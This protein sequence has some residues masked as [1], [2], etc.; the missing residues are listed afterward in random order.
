[1]LD[2]IGIGLGP[3]NLS[4]A[5]LLEESK[6][7]S[8]PPL[9]VKF[10]EQ[11]EKFNWH[12]GMILPQT[13]LQVPFLADLVTLIN[14]TSCYSFLN[15]LHKH[16]R[17]LK[18]YFVEDF[19]I[20]RKEYNHYCQWVA[21][22]LSS[23][24]FSSKVLDVLI[25][26]DQQ[27]FTVLVDEQ[28]TTNRYTAKNI[29]IGTGTHAT[30]PANLK[31]VADIAPHRCMHS[32]NFTDKFDLTK[33]T[34]K[35]SEDTNKDS[36]P[37]TLPKVLVL[38]SGQSSA[39]VYRELFD[40]QF[41]ENGNPQYQLDWMT[42]SA[43]FFPME[44]SPLGLEHFSPSYTDYFYQL[45]ESVKQDLLAKQGLLYK[46]MG[47][48]TIQDIY[49]RLYERSIAN[50]PLYS[51]II[52]NCAIE[53]I[54][55]ENDKLSISSYQVEQKKS[56]TESYDCVIAG[57]GYQHAFPSCFDNLLAR[58]SL[59][60]HNKPSI[61]RDYR[62][63]FEDVPLKGHVFVQNQELH[64]HGI[65]SPDLGLGAY[66]AGCIANQLL[67]R[68]QYDTDALTIFQNFGV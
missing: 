67:G 20:S 60:S 21:G 41:S 31:K 35:S 43:G 45:N 40:R 28:G 49:H 26:E 62:L 33:I 19:K 48:S 2:V 38:G 56:F 9:S 55:L 24:V 65:G 18:F 8:S 54:D 11:K 15:Y 61:E 53:D 36:A 6:K 23:L 4:L 22:Q 13:T 14:P 47:F 29:I 37:K 42:R 10:F 12:E 34:T 44:Y 30:L 57:T 16:H 5:S 50:E 7:D 17:L 3:F 25:D 27:A 66:R 63:V 64:S 32:A 46:G 51:K 68:K 59:D 52:S 1:M 39:E 58:A